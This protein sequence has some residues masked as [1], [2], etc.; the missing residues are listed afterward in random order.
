MKKYLFAIVSSFIILVF[1]FSGCTAGDS[2]LASTN[3][4]VASAAAETAT[5]DTS[6]SVLTDIESILENVYEQVSPSIVNVS[7]VQK[8]EVSNQIPDFFGFS[9][10]FSG[11]DSQDYYSQGLGSGFVWDKDGHIITNNHVVAGADKIS[12]TFQ[13][14]TTVSGE[15]VGSD[16]DSDLAVIQVDV[17]EDMLEPVQLADSSRV[18]VGQLAAAIGNP[19]GLEGT[20]TVG[21]VSALGR[22]LPVDSE[23]TGESTYSI[24]DIIQTDASINPGNS[25]GV[26]VDREGKVIGVTTAIISSSGS[27][28]GIGFAIPSTI[29][30]KVV[31]VLIDKGYYEHPW[32]GISCLSMSPDIADAMNLESTQR[33]A[34]IVD[35]VPDSP[36]EEAGLHGSD[37]QVTI[38]GADIRVGGDIITAI[39]DEPVLTSDDLITYLARSTEVGQSVTLTIVNQDEENQVKVT[40]G[41]R[42]KSEEQG[43][44]SKETAE[45]QAWLG[46]LGITVTSDIAEAMDLS[47]DQTGVLIE[48]VQQGSPADK[49]GLNGSYKPV[50]IDGQR[51]LIG[52]D[53]ITGMGDQKVENLE[54]LQSLLQQKDPGDKVTLKIVREGTDIEVG[55]TLSQRVTR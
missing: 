52:G 41:S 2:S 49:A 39:D 25:G 45:G 11:D 4:A 8:Q 43:T 30:E 27:N 3:T 12:V 9:S 46:V 54:Q 21:F 15:L 6:V 13:D 51:I 34:L 38:N 14:G 36:A 17:D 10:P 28:A 20:M 24:P 48:Q 31:P 44:Q 29:V 33:G 40:L 42:P 23:T 55:V 50:T 7:V 18:K 47:S 35:V 26:L 22:L 1:T 19:Y 32:V 53:I 37:R 16:V 5:A